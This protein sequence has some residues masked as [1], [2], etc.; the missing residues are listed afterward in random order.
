MRSASRLG[1]SDVGTNA[2]RIETFLDN[3]GK[4]LE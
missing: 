2:L 1:T 3:L 4:R